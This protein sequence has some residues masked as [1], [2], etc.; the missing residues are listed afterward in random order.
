MERDKTY[1]RDGGQGQERPIRK[2]TF[3]ER[4]AS[5]ECVKHTIM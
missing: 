5:S 4:N 1:L 2:G 3:E